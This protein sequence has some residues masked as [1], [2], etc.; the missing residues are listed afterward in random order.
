MTDTELLALPKVRV[1]DAA[2]YLQNGTSV[3]EIRVLAQ[4]GRCPYCEAFRGAGRYYYR[5][6]IGRLMQYKRG[7]LGLL[8]QEHAKETGA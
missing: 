1:A 6:N 3:Q 7:E 4:N 5:V 8:T 2:R